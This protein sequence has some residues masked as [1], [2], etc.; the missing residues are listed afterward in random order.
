[1][2]IPLCISAR[3]QFFACGEAAA[4]RPNM[5]SVH[6]VM[7]VTREQESCAV[8]NHLYNVSLTA[9]LATAQEPHRKR[10]WESQMLSLRS[11][12]LRISGGTAQELAMAHPKQ[13]ISCSQTHSKPQPVVQAPVAVVVALLPALPKDPRIHA[14][15]FAGLDAQSAKNP[16]IC[17]KLQRPAFACG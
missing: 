17:R 6:A 8:Q 11:N 14:C 9:F 16:L 3:S 13:A 7:H 2:W 4:G 15:A 10:R 5:P 12:S 1:M